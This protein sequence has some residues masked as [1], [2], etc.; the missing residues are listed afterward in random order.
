M[1]NSSW[2]TCWNLIAVSSWGPP[3][4]SRHSVYGQRATVTALRGRTALYCSPAQHSSAFVTATLHAAAPRRHRSTLTEE[5]GEEERRKLE[6]G[7]GS[8][9]GF[10]SMTENILQ[11]C[12]RV[13]TALLTRTSSS[14]SDEEHVLHFKLFN[15]NPLMC[16]SSWSS[17]CCPTLF[18]LK[19]LFYIP[20][21]VNKF[22]TIAHTVCQA[23]MI[24]KMFIFQF[25]FHLISENI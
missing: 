25:V 10:V 11:P 4:A 16:R 5:T 3:S 2:C 13:E 24:N 6:D 8:D 9:S 17:A 15:L 21:K 7:A 1:Q 20:V 22:P 19:G 14:L 18:K 12:K 23:E